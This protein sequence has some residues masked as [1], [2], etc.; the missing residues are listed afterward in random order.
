[1]AAAFL[2][3]FPNAKYLFQQAR[4]QLRRLDNHNFHK[5]TSTKLNQA[6]KNHYADH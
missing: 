3:D 1:M 4:K 2:L 6:D 5:N